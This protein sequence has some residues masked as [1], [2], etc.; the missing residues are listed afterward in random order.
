[1][2]ENT[3]PIKIQSGSIIVT[4]L[5]VMMF[6]SIIIF[7][8]ISLANTNLVRSRE[9]IMVLQS[10]YSAESGADA[11][12]AYINQNDTYVGT[13]GEKI[14]LND[15]AFKTTYQTTVTTN[16]NQKIINSTGKVYIPASSAI[17]KYTRNIEVI[18]QRTSEETA[19]SMVSR[20]I[21]NIESGVKNINAK[22]VYINGY[23]VM[24]KNTT[25]LIAE[26][27]TVG[28]KNTDAS[29]CSVGGIG[30]L[31]KPTIFTTPGQTKTNI[32]T[33]FNNCI[34]PP[35]NNS[36]S[37]FNVLANLNSINLIQSTLIP[38]SR[39]MDNDYQNSPTGCAD[40]TTGVFPRDIP[41]IGASKKTHYP[42]NGMGVS[43]SC[44]TSGNLDLATGQYNIR[45]HVHIRANLC[46]S[47]AC[48]PT[49]Y[50]PDQGAAGMKYV[51][52]EGNV[53]FDSL[54]TASGS[55]PIVFVVYGPDPDSKASVC[56]NGGSFYLGNKGDTSASAF[57]TMTQNGVCLDKTK[58]STSPAF[59]GMTG[60]NIYIATNPG[61]PFDLALD[62]NYPVESIP[63]NL[64][65][66]AIRY[67]RT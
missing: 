17:A 62:P 18:A 60:K 34:N 2:V 35:G 50:N 52:I 1:M 58:F 67:R 32:K 37:N 42:D 23:I 9:R 28:G 47:S 12:I 30:N 27:I 21:L 15:T 44:G 4:I 19:S 57:Y 66:K 51:F 3:K 14:I 61:T 10:L 43:T 16:G 25:N 63:I 65:W 8:L 59:G 24:N 6:L 53:N 46:A 11:S 31:I 22:N 13:N 7:S 38:F 39:F 41:S 64:A 5:V 54:Q 26:N 48:T 29:N 45:D 20:N 55:G 36:N 33:A 56:P 40:W 49:F